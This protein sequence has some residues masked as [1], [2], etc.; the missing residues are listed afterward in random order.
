MAY[1]DKNKPIILSCGVGAVLSQL[2][3]EDEKAPVAFASSTLGSAERNY[4][5][6]DKEDITVIFDVTQFHRY[7]VRRDITVVTDHIL[8][9]G[10]MDSTTPIPT[11]TS[12]RML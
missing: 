1:H 10:I 9:L 8:L 6:L 3:D 11:T 7:V 12:S 5:Q 2:M 4:A